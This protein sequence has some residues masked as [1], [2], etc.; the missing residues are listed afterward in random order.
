MV[1]SNLWLLSAFALMGCSVLLDVPQ[2]RAA[3]AAEPARS[4]ARPTPL[5][6]TLP[7]LPMEAVLDRDSAL[8]LLPRDNAGNV[9]W[10][11]A[12]REGVIRPRRGLPGASP[13]DPSAFG[14]DFLFGEME[15]RFPHSSHVA[16]TTCQNCHPSIFPR[17]GETDMS[18]EAINAGQLCGRC[19]GSVAFSADTCERCH[20]AFNMPADRVQPRLLGDLVMARADEDAQGA[21][22][23]PPS[24]F[25]HWVH[26]VRYTCDSCHP[27]PFPARAGETLL[28]M[29][30]M[31]N[32]Q[33][34]GACHNGEAAFNTL[35]C[36]RCHRP[37][38]EERQAAP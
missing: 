7:P 30:S 25:P 3:P 1:R 37:P 19:H 27:E 9:D 8:A 26:R 10:S 16:W 29:E 12:I 33:Y 24:V 17:P 23:Y 22:A 28:T 36:D 21:G 32:G 15:T 31:A 14:Y 35:E 13:P 2:R 5:R 6:D 11:A 4:V 34:C 20:P 38:Y 18:M